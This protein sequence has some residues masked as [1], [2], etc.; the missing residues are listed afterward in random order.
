MSQ[1]SIWE[2]LEI[3]LLSRGRRGVERD[4][5]ANEAGGAETKNRGMGKRIG[6]RENHTQEIMSFIFYCKHANKQANS[7]RKSEASFPILAPSTHK[8]GLVKFI[9]KL[10]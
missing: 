3:T 2:I 7:F 9:H 1:L 5:T 6:R 10:T 8:P 4:K